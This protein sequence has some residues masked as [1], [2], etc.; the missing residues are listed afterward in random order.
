MMPFFGIYTPRKPNPN[1]SER[2]T[3]AC[4]ELESLL[5]KLEPFI[6]LKRHLTNLKQALFHSHTKV[7]QVAVKQLNILLLDGPSRHAT[8]RRVALPRILLQ[9]E[10]QLLLIGQ[11]LSSGRGPAPFT[12][13]LTG[14]PVK[15]SSQLLVRSVR[16]KKVQSPRDNSGLRE[17]RGMSV[18]TARH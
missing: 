12:K 2:I 13:S 14:A 6:V 4:V 11:T 10:W 16:D 1:I 18:V 3:M 9:W 8:Y 15:A 7:V 5:N 17:T